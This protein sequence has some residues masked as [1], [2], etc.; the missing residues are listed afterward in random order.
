VSNFI[1][2]PLQDASSQPFVGYPLAHYRRQ[3]ARETGVFVGSTV[4][5]GTTSYLVDDRYPI[6]SNLDQGDLYAGK[7]LLRPRASLDEDKVRIV[8]ERGYDPSTGTLRPD[9]S[10]V[11]APATD[12]PYEIHGTIEPWEQMIDLINAGLKRCL[13]VAEVGLTVLPGSNSLDLRAAA[14]WLQDARWVRQ[15]G[16]WPGGT[17]PETSDPFNYP[18]RA[19]VEPNGTGLT[20]R[21]DHM[22]LGGGTGLVMR[23]IKRAYDHCRATAEGLFGEQSGVWDE[24]SEGPVV[25]EWV[26]AG[27]LVEFFERYGDVV[28]GGS[29]DEVELN[30]KKAAAR[31]DRMSREYFNLPPYTL[32][33]PVKRGWLVG[34][35]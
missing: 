8:S 6:K 11:N 18:F 4:R 30:Q 23:C 5:S 12:E 17:A 14:P 7:W 21:W 26:A 35:Y 32:L 1:L 16:W 28:S 19:T 2:Q 13:V 25:P 27:A 24:D 10:W 3:I 29:R 15:V 34:R 22:W 9:S 33:Q 31:F 20:L